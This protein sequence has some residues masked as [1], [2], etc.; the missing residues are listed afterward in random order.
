MYLKKRYNFILFLIT[1][2]GICDAQ[3]F[4][5]LR[6]EFIPT[7]KKKYF[8]GELIVMDVAIFN[9]NDLE[10]AI[11]RNNVFK[12][13]YS[14]TYDKNS[15][16]FI[17]TD[18][19]KPTSKGDALIAPR[20]IPKHWEPLIKPNLGCSI[21][22]TSEEN[23]NNGIIPPHS[24]LQYSL[25]IADF[26]DEGIY[27]SPM[28]PLPIGKWEISAFANP[29]IP[30]R[31]VAKHEFEIVAPNPVQAEE[32][33]K[34]TKAYLATSS[35]ISSLEKSDYRVIKPLKDT[36][37][38]FEYF[39]NTT[40]EIFKEKA[41]V[42]LFNLY[43][44]FSYGDNC[45]F[46]LAHFSKIKNDALLIYMLNK[47]ADIYKDRVAPK[48][49]KKMDRIEVYNSILLQI[50]NRNPE[51]SQTFINT[52]VSQ[53]MKYSKKTK[54]YRSSSDAKENVV[55]LNVNEIKQLRNYAADTK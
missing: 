51:I 4:D 19:A 48:F 45:S 30:G 28:F 46:F 53:S 18:N 36:I 3:S 5:K 6:M 31:L 15:Q 23:I 37:G 44:D 49:G 24:S 34:Y 12:D 41:F 9:D 47:F 7:T 2:S 39:M 14:I 29:H 10:V 8:H 32:L 16:L 50:R 52:I 20:I 1:L 17:N 26:L 21:I 13:L 43:S 35:K 11:C 33:R 40:D 54:N 42:N 27:G 55:L 25:L 22:S 38:M